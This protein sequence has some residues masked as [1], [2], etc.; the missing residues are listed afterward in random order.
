MQL[1]E[2]CE[3]CL[4]FC[5]EREIPCSPPISQLAKA[6]GGNVSLSSSHDACKLTRKS[7]L[8]STTV[9]SHRGEKVYESLFPTFA[10]RSIDLKRD[11]LVG[12]I[13]HPLIHEM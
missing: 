7:T 13:P 4:L 2:L 6:E 11:F 1:V 10:H 8:T 9:Y 5:S 12:L 3:M